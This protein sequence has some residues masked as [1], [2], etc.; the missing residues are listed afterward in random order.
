MTA[1]MHL[2][3]LGGPDRSG[4]VGTSL[5]YVREVSQFEVSTVHEAVYKT[6]ARPS[7]TV[8]PRTM[9]RYSAGATTTAKEFIV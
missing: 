5:A 3:T 1:T 2:L 4:V 9:H 7:C 6:Q 8:T